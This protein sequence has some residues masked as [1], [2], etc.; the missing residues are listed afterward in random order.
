MVVSIVNNVKKTFTGIKVDEKKIE[1]YHRLDLDGIREDHL[2]KVFDQV[3]T[4][5]N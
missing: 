1:M 3:S 2:C 4:K 5:G